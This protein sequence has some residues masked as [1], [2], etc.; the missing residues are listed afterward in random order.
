MKTGIFKPIF[1]LN[2]VLVE[3]LKLAERRLCGAYFN[4]SQI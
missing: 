2:S 1:Y 3:D 4:Q